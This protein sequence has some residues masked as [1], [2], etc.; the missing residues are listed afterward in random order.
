MEELRDRHRCARRR[1]GARVV[2]S[3]RRDERR[4]ARRPR[5]GTGDAHLRGR[6]RRS[7]DRARL[8]P[9]GRR[10][11]V[12]HGGS[13]TPAGTGTSVTLRAAYSEARQYLWTAG[14]ST[15]SLP[16]AP[17]DTNLKLGSVANFVPGDTLEVDQETAT[18]AAVG[19][20]SR[21]TTLFGAAAPGDTNVKVA[22]TTGIANGDTL[23]IDIGG[24]TESVTVSNVGTQGRATT[25][26]AAA[27]AGATNVK[28]ASVTGLAAGDTLLVD[29]G[30]AQESR[31]IAT[32]GTAGANGTGVTLTVRCPRRTRVARPCRTR[33]PASRS[34]RR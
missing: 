33:E 25:L 15:L 14:S 21:S 9:R 30:A 27:S 18:I 29:S 1:A 22:A 13:V 28:V 20:Q 11:P 34:R 6:R 26:A 17:G 5:E 10:P 2:D 3:G 16:A 4:R 12:L 19:T 7:H 8:R 32:V 31:T 23:R 24:A